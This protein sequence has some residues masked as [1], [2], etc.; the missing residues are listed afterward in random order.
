MSQ[1]QIRPAVSTDLPN[2]M[3]LDHTCASDYVWQMEIDH[4]EEQAQVSF[5]K[6]RLPR[7]V[8]V[9]YP[10]Q[11]GLLSETWNRRI[12]GL[13]VAVIEQK[14]VGY[15]RINDA[16]IPHTAWITDLVVSARLRRQGIAAR[17]ILSAQA[18]ALERG[19]TRIQI[20]MS[21]KN[22][23]A[24]ALSAKMG[25]EFCGYND[26]YY[27]TQDIAIFFGRNLPGK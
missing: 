26:Q 16:L 17:L 13:L 12:I 27:E 21:S 8:V 9:S 3:A 22:Y 24:S 14:E 18:W 4:D 25:Y 1:V 7:T 6:I 15:I 19:N 20:E 11:V 10:R 2:L 23:P 5:R